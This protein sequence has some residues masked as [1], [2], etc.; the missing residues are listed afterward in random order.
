MANSQR[1][2]VYPGSF[3]PLTNG[4]VDII[5][6][7]AALFDVVGSLFA[8]ALNLVGLPLQLSDSDVDN[9]EHI[10]LNTP[11]LPGQ[12]AFEITGSLN[13]DY[14]F[15]WNATAAIS[16]TGTTPRICGRSTRQ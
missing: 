9:V 14:A 15:A 10:Y 16:T 7:G 2:A 5:R 8:L 11:F 3:D 13:T 1:I 12:Y 6:R 4:H